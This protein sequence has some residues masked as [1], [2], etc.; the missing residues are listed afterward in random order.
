MLKQEREEQ[1]AKI[2]ELSAK[3]T[4]EEF[5]MNNKDTVKLRNKA[6]KSVSELEA[7]IE[8]LKR[9]IDKQRVELDS[10]KRTNS[11]LNERVERS[12][13]EPALRRRIEELSQALHSAQMKEVNT[14]ENERNLKKM[15]QANKHL[16]EE[17]NREI[18]RYNLLESKFRDLLMKYNSVS[19]ENQSNKN[20]LYSMIT[21]SQFPKNVNLLDNDMPS[22]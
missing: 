18:D 8:N 9:V 5:G 2:Q 4:G 21:G 12:A 3:L 14:E 13:N 19:K 10:T 1:L 11:T 20:T 22:S 16:R 15:I 17:L 7:V 6:T